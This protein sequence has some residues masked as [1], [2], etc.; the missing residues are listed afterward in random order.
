MREVPEGTK[1]Q[2]VDQ[3]RSESSGPHSGVQMVEQSGQ[4]GEALYRVQF[5]SRWYLHAQESPYALN[6][7][8]EKF[9]QYNL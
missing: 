6:P 7:I 5:S 2:E 4:E 3:L 8:T 9:P 1:I